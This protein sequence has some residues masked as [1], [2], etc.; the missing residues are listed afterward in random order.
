MEGGPPGAGFLSLRK[1]AP[2]SAGRTPHEPRKAAGLLLN[3][4]RC[5]NAAI[6]DVEEDALFAVVQV[7]VAELLGYAAAHSR[8]CL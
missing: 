6:A 2:F 3:L 7:S 1:L 5:Y 8:R 4:N